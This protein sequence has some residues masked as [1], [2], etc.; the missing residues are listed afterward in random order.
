M[1][2]IPVSNIPNQSLS[3]QID[4][5]NY[6]IR[7]H[8]CNDNQDLGTNILAVDIIKDNTIVVTGM[9]AVSGTPLLPYPYLTTDGNFI[10]VTQNDEYPNWRLLGVNQYL[11]YVSFSEI[12]DII[13]GI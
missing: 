10:F 11:I 12:R 5:I 9:R 2:N 13:N 8:A 4:N 1:I 7:I 3:I 6:I